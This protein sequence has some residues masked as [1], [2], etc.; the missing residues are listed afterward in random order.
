MN[1]DSSNET[2]MNDDSSNETSRNY[3]IY[4]ETLR[5]EVKYITEATNDKSLVNLSIKEDDSSKN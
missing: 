2:S 3:D 4:K 5:K 1:N